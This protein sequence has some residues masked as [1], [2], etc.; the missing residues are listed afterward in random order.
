MNKSDCAFESLITKVRNIDGQG[1]TN[2]Q[3]TV[4]VG[5]HDIAPSLM[6]KPVDCTLLIELRVFNTN[7][8]W[9]NVVTII[10]DVINDQREGTFGNI[11]EGNSNIVNR[12]INIGV[13]KNSI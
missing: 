4:V 10:D 12:K 3:F 6:F 11:I 7:S 8:Q 13:L 5:S 2:E 1:I 9:S